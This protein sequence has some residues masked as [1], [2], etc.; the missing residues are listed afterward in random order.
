MPHQTRIVS[1]G[2]SGRSVR[3]SSGEVLHPPADWLL[4]PPGDATLTRRVKAAGPTWTVQ[5]KRGRKIFSRG[6]WASS[7]VVEQVRTELAAERATPEYAKKQVAAAR[8]REHQQADYVED[9]HA[10]VLTFLA[11]SPG[12]ADLGKRLARA[13]TEHATP[14]GSGTVART[15]RI[16]IERRA[17]A[18]VI[19]ILHP[20]WDERPLACVVKKPGAELTKEQIYDHL[21]KHS[22]CRYV[23]HPLYKLRKAA[24]IVRGRTWNADGYTIG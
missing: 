13:V 24:L 9:F 10:A 7:D 20:K 12:H 14:V 1:P 18:A 19:A 8:R 17:E 6:V 11:F 3:A 4:L 23:V 2:P 16:P 21:L 5:E 15:K 22:L